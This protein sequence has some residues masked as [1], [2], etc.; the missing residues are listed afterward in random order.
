MDATTLLPL[1]DH[2]TTTITLETLAVVFIDLLAGEASC[3]GSRPI[4]AN[5]ATALI[6][7]SDS[8][9][10]RT[11]QKGSCR[12]TAMCLCCQHLSALF[13]LIL[14]CAVIVCLQFA[15]SLGESNRH[16]HA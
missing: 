14:Q 3:T 11:C 12:E 16:G 6:L 15:A 9:C 10:L 13:R 4:K 5:S 2:V 8:I 7:L 1:L